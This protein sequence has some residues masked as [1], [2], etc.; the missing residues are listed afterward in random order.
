MRWI[1]H[2]QS[3]FMVMTLNSGYSLM[4]DLDQKPIV[5]YLSD[6]ITISTENDVVEYSLRDIR[7]IIYEGIEDGVKGPSASSNIRITHYVS[8]IKIEGMPI[9]ET[10]YLYGIDGKI[11]K[12]MKPS[13]DI[14]TIFISDLTTGIY[15]IKLGNISYKFIRK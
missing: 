6:I 13:S 15:I 9:N 4:F 14:C 10:L 2:A 3:Q 1:A 5:T 11:I 7:N 12:K 8:Y